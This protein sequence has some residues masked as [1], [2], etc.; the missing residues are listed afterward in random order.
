M[1]L[2]GALSVPDGSIWSVTAAVCVK[3][4]NA[5]RSQTAKNLSTSQKSGLNFFMF[6]R[7]ALFFV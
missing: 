4:Q 6:T 2:L 1:W 3:R 7:T 5:P